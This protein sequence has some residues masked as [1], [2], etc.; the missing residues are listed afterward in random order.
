MSATKG[1]MKHFGKLL[2]KATDKQLEE[3]ENILEDT[4]KEKEG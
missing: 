2:E 1:E 3:M 4:I